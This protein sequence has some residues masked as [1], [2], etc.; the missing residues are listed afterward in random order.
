MIVADVF[1][2]YAR[3]DVRNDHRYAGDDKQGRNYVEK[4]QAPR[5]AAGLVLRGEKIHGLIR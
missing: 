2:S 3:E 4:D 1:V 5:Y